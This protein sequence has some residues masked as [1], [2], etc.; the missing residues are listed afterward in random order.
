MPITRTFLVAR[1][2]EPAA[3]LSFPYLNQQPASRKVMAPHGAAPL[4]RAP[5]LVRLNI[6]VQQN[7]ALIWLILSLGCVLLLGAPIVIDGGVLTT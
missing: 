4:R 6:G 7:Q 2:I 5:S 3:I 1:H